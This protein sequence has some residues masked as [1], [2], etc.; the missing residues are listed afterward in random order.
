MTGKCWKSCPWLR[1]MPSKALC[2]LN[3]NIIWTDSW[4]GHIRQGE[5]NRTLSLDKS[6]TNKLIMLAKNIDSTSY[7][8]Q[9]IV[10][11]YENAL[12]VPSCSYPTR[13]AGWEVEC[14]EVELEDQKP[15]QV[16]RLAV[17]QEIGAQK[18]NLL[19]QETHKASGMASYKELNECSF[20]VQSIE[21]L[22]S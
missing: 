3:K 22:F 1:I 14:Q 4:L 20:P 18:Y 7:S 12:L 15:W 5:S 16:R 11:L 9:L 13:L 6:L 21:C 19:L 10:W 17:H 8:W 2:D